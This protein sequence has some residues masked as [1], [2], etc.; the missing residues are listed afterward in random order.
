MFVGQSFQ[1]MAPVENEVFGINFVNDLSAGE[2]IVSATFNIS[3]DT[4]VDPSP[5]SHFVGLPSFTGATALQRI[6]GLLNGVTY[7]LEA[8]VTTSLH[9]TLS[10]HSRVHCQSPS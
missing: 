1:T 9:N 8:V 2:S 3:V 6:S 5:S 10:L 7:I 4:G